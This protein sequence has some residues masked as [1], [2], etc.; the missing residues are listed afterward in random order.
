MT[1]ARLIL[2]K[3]HDYCCNIFVSLMRLGSMSRVAKETGYET[4]FVSRRIAALEKSVASKLFRANHAPLHADARS[5]CPSLTA[6]CPTSWTLSADSRWRPAPSRPRP[7]TSY[8][9]FAVHIRGPRRR[10]E[11][12]LRHTLLPRTPSREDCRR[13]R[14]GSSSGLLA[15]YCPLP[16]CPGVDPLAPARRD[17]RMAVNFNSVQ[18]PPAT[19]Y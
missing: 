6:F 3:L 14:Q 19:W 2:L 17:L 15:L 11:L 8:S 18:G 4:S 10:A 13:P 1:G 12:A 7:A 9:R 16:H 5:A